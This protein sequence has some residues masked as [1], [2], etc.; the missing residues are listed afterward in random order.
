MFCDS[1]DLEKKVIEKIER[2][3]KAKNSNS[4]S[5]VESFRDTAWCGVPFR[6]TEFLKENREKNQKE[7]IISLKIGDK[8]F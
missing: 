6:H 5:C 7:K 2:S 4:P 8:K 1:K 3:A